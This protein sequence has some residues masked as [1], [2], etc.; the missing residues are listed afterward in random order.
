L[1]VRGEVKKGEVTTVEFKAT[2]KGTYKIVCL[3]HSDHSNEG[4]MVAYLMVQ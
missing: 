4:P 2:E 3:T 1:P